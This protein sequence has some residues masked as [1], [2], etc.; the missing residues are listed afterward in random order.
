M[1]ILRRRR[2]R[3]RRGYLNTKHNTSFLIGFNFYVGG[4][5]GGEIRIKTKE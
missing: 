3:R 5:E 2:R 1:N 4:G